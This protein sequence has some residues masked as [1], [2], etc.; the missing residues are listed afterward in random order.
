MTINDDEYTPF[1]SGAFLYFSSRFTAIASNRTRAAG[2]S[3]NTSHM[4]FLLNTNKSLYPTERTLAVRLFPVTKQWTHTRDRC[5]Q[6]LLNCHKINTEKFVGCVID[7]AWKMW[8][9]YENV[10]NICTKIPFSY[11]NCIALIIMWEGGK[12]GVKINYCILLNVNDGQK[13]QTR[14]LFEQR[15]KGTQFRNE[16][17]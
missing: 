15:G 8:C 10:E 5:E 17:V 13:A 6:R 14:N 7:D 9:S 1:S 4:S 3:F 16:T 11:S 12:K 2:Y